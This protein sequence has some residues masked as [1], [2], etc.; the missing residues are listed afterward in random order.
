MSISLETE[1]PPRELTARA[2]DFLRGQPNPFES[3]VRPQRRDDRFGDLHVPA[4]LK[5]PRDLLFKVIDAYRL[6][7]YHG[8]QDLPETRV[9]SIVGARGA[10]KTHMLES[11]LR[12]DDGLGQIIVRPSYFEKSQ[13]FEEYLLSH[14]VSALA[15]DDRPFAGIARA[16]TRQLLLQAIR[17]LGPIDRLWVDMPQSGWRW[18]LLW[19]GGESRIRRFDDLAEA[20]AAK[21]DRDDLIAL[22][23][24]HGMSPQQA[25]Q[26]IEAQL[27]MHEKGDG[28][29]SAVRRHLYSAMAKSA[30][31]CEEKALDQFLEDDFKPA[32][33]RPFFR[34]E[35]VRQLLHTIVEAC[36][37]F[38]RP[39]V[40]AFD[41]LEGFLS[42]G[43]QFDGAAARAFLDG[44]AQ[45]VDAGR[46][47]PFLLFAESALYAKIRSHANQFALDRLG[48]G[49]PLYRHGPVDLIELRPPS[50]EEMQ[51]LIITR[52]RRLLHRCPEARQLPDEFPFGRD[53]LQK[54]EQKREMGLRA[55]LLVLRD[56]YSRVV[57]GREPSAA[58]APLPPVPK[59]WTGVFDGH[60]ARCLS[61]S[62]QKMESTR[63]GNRQAFHAGLAQLL[64]RAGTGDINGWRIGGVEAVVQAGE[65]VNF[66]IVSVLEWQRASGAS[67]KNGGAAKVTTGVGFLLAG[68]PGMPK[69]LASK[70]DLFRDKG[71]AVD[72]LVVLWPRIVDNDDTV[73]ALPK[74]TGEVWSASRWKNR[75][76]LRT[77]SDNDMRILLALPDWFEALQNEPDQP[78]PPADVRAFLNKKCQALFPLLLPPQP[79]E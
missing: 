38:R 59:D 32:G 68:G 29:L 46:G 51:Q 31:L 17:G 20:L 60:W 33:T 4:L 77:I 3:L 45:T 47:F 7:E 8:A 56:E 11:L 16:L 52:V 14:L 10:G 69:D 21:R 61:A 6:T 40:F 71:R 36:A 48:Q 18:R 73:S 70:F 12:R 5:E 74:A 22:V 63:S 9:V 35:V 58:P 42:P 65:H 15:A 39:V 19:R 49:V 27:Q 66:G 2:L 54:L 23:Q 72:A 24:Q 79:K 55:R 13:S 26:L 34:G 76:E 53:F 30:L 62:S 41:N 67:E 44:L 75:T 43:D 64:E 25:L 28:V 37:L 57:Y 50:V 78:I 1:N